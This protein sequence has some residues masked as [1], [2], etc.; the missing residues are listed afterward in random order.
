MLKRNIIA[1][2]LGQGW[3]IATL[4]IAVPF[5]IDYLG[6]EAYSLIAVFA[7]MQT[8]LSLLDLGL[9]AV[10]GRE[11]ARF[12]AGTHSDKS[13]LNLLRSIEVVTLIISII[14]LISVW[15]SSSWLASNWLNELELNENTIETSF[16]LMG[17]VISFRFIEGI[18]TGSLAGLQKQVLQNGV[19]VVIS[20]FQNIGVIGVLI[21]VSPEIEVFFIWQA[22]LSFIAIVIFRILVYKAIPVKKQTIRFSWE[23]LS[24]IW[25]FAAGITGITILGIAVTQ[26]DKLLASQILTAE[27]FAYYALAGLVASGLDLFTG[28]IAAA[29]YPHFVK[30]HALKKEAELQNIFHKS[31]QLISVFTGSLASV[32]IVFS[33][34]FIMV[35][36]GDSELSFQVAPIM[37]ILLVGSLAHCMLWIPYQVQLAHGW[38]SLNI[39][40]NAIGLILFV[41]FLLYLGQ[42]Y[43]VSGIAWTWVAL[44]ILYLVIG[45]HFMHRKILTDEKFNWYLYDLLIPISSSFF[46][47][48][49][50]FIFMPT[51]LNRIADI[52]VLVGSLVIVLFFSITTSPLIRKLIW[53]NILLFYSLKGKK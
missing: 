53:D 51:D 1:N 7:I 29:V 19:L 2:N 27:I 49:L 4:F 10:L 43:G 18:Y 45:G 12:T 35:W 3:R 37:T 33:E 46:A 36:T 39:K 5:Y 14:I 44:N 22:L 23:A 15:M 42:L 32:L 28:P 20:T 16:A 52:F 21:W 34:R 26:F 9:K 47:A 38:V 11:M 17:V 48:L 25:R 13:I 50:C 31:A 30:L 41:P 8:W 24:G 40:L 6:I